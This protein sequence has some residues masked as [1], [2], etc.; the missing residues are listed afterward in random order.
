MRFIRS[1]KFLAVIGMLAFSFAVLGDA[2]LAFAQKDDV[3]E[4]VQ[5]AGGGCNGGDAEVSGLAQ[6]IINIL[7]L[8]AGIAAVIVIIISGLRMIIANGESDT[9]KTARNGILYA[10]IGLVIIAFAQ[11]IVRFVLGRLNV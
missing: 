3:C 5:L 2:P 4:G 6:T 7:S 9:I 10:I 8:I 1:L 11:I